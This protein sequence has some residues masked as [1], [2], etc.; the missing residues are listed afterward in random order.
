MTTRR[1]TTLEKSSICVNQNVRQMQNKLD[2][3]T[4]VEKKT[5]QIWVKSTVVSF[6]PKIPRDQI[7]YWLSKCLNRAFGFHLE[8]YSGLFDALLT[9]W[10]LPMMLVLSLD[11]TSNMPYYRC[12]WI[13]IWLNRCVVNLFSIL[14]PVKQFDYFLST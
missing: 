5:F 7:S 12:E 2:K 3:I 1:S 9:P 6:Y 4:Y 11:L 13:V 8:P 14:K 10:G